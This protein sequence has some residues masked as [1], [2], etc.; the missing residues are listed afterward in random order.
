MQAAFICD[1]NSPRGCEAQAVRPSSQTR[2]SPILACFFSVSSERT[3]WRRRSDENGA[4]EAALLCMSSTHR[5]APSMTPVRPQVCA[6]VRSLVS[7]V[8]PRVLYCNNLFL[9][10]F[11][12]GRTLRMFAAESTLLS[13]AL[14]VITEVSKDPR[15]D[16]MF[17]PAE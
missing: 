14:T 13:C 4:R 12:L 15:A 3:K 2:A 10:V 11:A 8:A 6:C 17:T 9:C 16:L 5:A 1:R 7:K